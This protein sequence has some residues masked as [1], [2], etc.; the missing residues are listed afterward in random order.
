MGEAR[1]QIAREI[2]AETI[3]PNAEDVDTEGNTLNPDG[4]VTYHPKVRENLDIL[5]R[6]DLMGFTLPYKY[7]GLNCP[8]LVYTMATEIVSRADGSLMNLFWL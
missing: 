1:C 8:N 6:A 4:T 7:G 2:A 5:G 3:A